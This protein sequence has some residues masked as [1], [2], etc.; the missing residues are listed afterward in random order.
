MFKLE[1]DEQRLIF[2]CAKPLSIALQENAPLFDAPLNWPLVLDLAAKHRVAPLLHAYLERHQISVPGAV[3]DS[4]KAHV[5]EQALANLFQTKELIKVVRQLN[6]AGV[7]A[8]PFKGPALGYYLYNNL[9]IRPFSDLD[10][11]IHRHQFDEVKA[12]LRANGY[13]PFRKL[14]QEEEKKFLATKMGFEFVRADKQAVIEVHWSFL[15]TVHAFK[16]SEKEVWKNSQEMD[17]IGYPVKMFSPAHLIVYL[18]AHGSKSLWTR[19]RWICDVAEL[20][21]KHTD[22]AFWNATFQVATTSKSH[23][24]L[25]IGLLLA[26]ELLGAPLPQAHLKTIFSDRRA[27]HL[28][29]Q[30]NAALW[31]PSAEDT[32]A[33][34]PV[35]FH[36][37]MHGHIWDRIPYYLHLFQIWSVPTNKDKAFVRLPRYLDFLYVLIK[38]IRMLLQRSELPDTRSKAASHRRGS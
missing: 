36:L 19:L 13:H 14:N 32:H 5:N 38:P 17:L 31:D 23:R 9:S 16:L 8:M 20:M 6:E 22:E 3:R 37:E 28:S 10:I 11:L 25:S 30:V 1:R 15:N 2:A 27:V 12:V 7:E 26:H 35:T 29:K 24:M 4:L 21:K 33:V 18:C 34:D